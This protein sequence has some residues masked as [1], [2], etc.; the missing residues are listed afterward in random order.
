MSY[1]LKILKDHPIVYYP[2][3][4]TYSSL[5]GSYQDVL[6]TYDTYQEF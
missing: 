4:E 1:Q 3:S 2:I 6:D 5:I